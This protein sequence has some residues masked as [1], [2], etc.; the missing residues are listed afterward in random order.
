[1]NRYTT[2]S[3]M[4]KP[5]KVSLSLLRKTAFHTKYMMKADMISPIKKHMK[6]ARYTTASCIPA[7]VK[8]V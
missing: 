7:L 2:I 1:M 3:S 4:V 6:L 5:M 8:G